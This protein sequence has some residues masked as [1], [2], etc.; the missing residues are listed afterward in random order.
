MRGSAPLQAL[1]YTYDPVGNITTIEDDAQQTLF[2]GNSIVK[3]RTTYTYDRIYRLVYAL[4]REHSGQA[5][6]DQTRTPDGVPIPS[7]TDTQAMRTYAETYQYDPV[8]NFAAMIHAVTDASGNFQNLW[9]RTY[10]T[11]AASNRLL[12]T[13]IGSGVTSPPTTY[14][15]DDAGNIKTMSGVL[16]LDWN[17]R[18]QLTHSGPSGSDV[19][20]TYDAANQ[21]VRKVSVEANGAVAERIYLG[22][23]EIYREHS[24]GTLAA[25][26]PIT[27]ERRTLHVIDDKRRVALVE[28][29]T[30]GNDGS[31]A[32]LVRYQL[33]NHLGSAVLELDGGANLIS[34][35]EYHPYGTTAYR[36]AANALA[37]SPKRYAFI[38]RERDEET[39]L[40]YVGARYYAA[41]IGRWTSCDP[42]GMVDGTCRYS[43]VRSNPIR[44]IDEGG[45][46]AVD[47]TKA[48]RAAGISPFERQAWTYAQSHGFDPDTTA[49]LKNS[50]ASRGDELT[51]ATQVRLATVDISAA[52]GQAHEGHYA[53]AAKHGVLAL[54]HSA[55]GAIFGDTP[56]K[57]ARNTAIMAGSQLGLKY[58]LKALGYVGRALGRS[59]ARTPT[60]PVEVAPVSAAPV[61]A[62]SLTSTGKS[63]GG[64][65]GTGAAV[66]PGEAA[67]PPPKAGTTR[68]YRGTYSP[69]VQQ[70]SAS[71]RGK[72]AT[73][74]PSG[75]EHFLDKAAAEQHAFNPAQHPEG[76]SVSTKDWAAGQYGSHTIHYDVPQTVF[77]QLP[78]GDPAL[79]ERVFRYSI[80]EQYRVGVTRH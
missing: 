45:S 36:A 27:L 71:M 51:S 56:A 23:Y 39:G 53:A 26:G 80:R 9:T 62:P 78:E 61:E 37:S 25:L 13:V 24:A 59:L 38:A 4:G 49:V 17:Y 28:L 55:G 73:E 70:V 69:K 14:A 12:S 42:K 41:W 15:H 35:E 29:R 48:D 72:P 34:Y 58:V 67:I 57:T 44:N 77:D 2:V 52:V 31:P 10:T 21:R 5:L 20:F 33:D 18:N 19:Y 3:P 54:L 30:Q 63:G 64:G 40:Y 6:P 74:I 66:P 16:A 46:Q 68:V 7:P 32:Q 76:V 11:D 8:A 79:F 75:G 1:S 65:L 50:I 22:A 60:L 43:Y 47:T